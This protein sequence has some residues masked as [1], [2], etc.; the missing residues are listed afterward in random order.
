[1]N[2]QQF[3]NFNYLD[4]ARFMDWETFGEFK[5]EFLLANGF[6]DGHD[7]YN[8][9]KGFTYYLHR[10][11]YNGCVFHL[12]K[13]HKSGIPVKKYVASTYVITGALSALAGQILIA[14]LNSAQPVAG[15][16]L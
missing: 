15:I 2:N 13:K 8:S 7:E 11:I 10:Y 14:R 6:P 3:E 4:K 12:V 16:G 1:M 5:K 9:D